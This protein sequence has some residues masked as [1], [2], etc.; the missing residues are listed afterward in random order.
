VLAWQQTLSEQSAD[1]D[2]NENP[3]HFSNPQI[4]ELSKSPEDSVFP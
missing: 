1:K 4:A 3:W 2:S